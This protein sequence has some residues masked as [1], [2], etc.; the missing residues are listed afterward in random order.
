MFLR[1]TLQTEALPVVIWENRQDNK[2][3]ARPPAGDV[4][5]TKDFA[6]GDLQRYSKDIQGY[7]RE[8]AL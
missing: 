2:K 5:I 4:L 7:P 3:L 8:I 6:V 1:G